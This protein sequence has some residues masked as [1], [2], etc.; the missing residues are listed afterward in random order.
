MNYGDDIA[1]RPHRLFVK[2]FNEGFQAHE[3][4]TDDGQ[5]AF[6]DLFINGDFPRSVTAQDLIGKTVEVDYTH[7]F[8]WLASNVR[9]T[10]EMK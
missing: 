8:L 6:V 4:R 5:T 9:L 1:P 7:G 2:S 3:C 10:E